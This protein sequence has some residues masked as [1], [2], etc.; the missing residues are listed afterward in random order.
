MDK[1]MYSTVCAILPK[2][3][4]AMTKWWLKATT[5]CFVLSFLPIEQFQLFFDFMKGAC[6]TSGCCISI[7]YYVFAYIYNCRHE[8]KLIKQ[9]YMDNFSEI[10]S[11]SNYIIIDGIVHIVLPVSIYYYWYEYVSIWGSV[12]AFLFHRSWS[13]VNSN[14]TTIYLDGSSI[15]KV[16]SLP[17]WGWTVVYIGEFTVLVLSTVLA[18]ISV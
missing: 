1:G 13:I 11:Y 9:F 2:E 3:N 17:V 15:Y 10:V 18:I 5:M 8:P 7:G 12:A 4:E 16:N 14:F 6:A